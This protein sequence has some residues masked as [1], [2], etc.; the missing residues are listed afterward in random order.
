MK[1]LP[2]L[3]LCAFAV[4]MLVLGTIVGGYLP[5]MFTTLSCL[6]AVMAWG[7]AHCRRRDTLTCSLAIAFSLAG[8]AAMAHV[9]NT[10][11]GF[12]TGVAL[13]FV[14]H[15]FYTSFFL[16]HGKV[17]KW[18]LLFSGGAV[19]VYVLGWLLPVIPQLH[20][21]GAIT[22]YALVSVLSFA[23]S[24]GMYKLERWGR[25]L[26]VVGISLLLFSD[27]LIAQNS[28]LNDGALSFLILPT[29]FLSHII[30]TFAFVMYMP[31]K[32]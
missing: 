16:M 7:T 12:L 29:Y 17:N 22:A 9:G 6:I 3:C 15:L 10:D 21:R 25:V 2:I 20:I 19:M 1:R 24:C 8:D 31:I 27:I 26:C 4:C 28:F 13:F 11:V 30:I 18:I 32:K 14:A 5:R 23:A